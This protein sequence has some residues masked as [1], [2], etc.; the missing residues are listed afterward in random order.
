[1][2]QVAAGPAVPLLVEHEAIPDLL[3]ASGAAAPMAA[4][5]MP[6]PVAGSVDL[7]ALE[8]AAGDVVALTVEVDWEAP[9]AIVVMAVERLPADTQ[10]D[11]PSAG[12]SPAR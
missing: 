4:M 11:I 9:S 6:F 5:T 12:R 7:A 8:L 1:M 10:L 3:D 2:R